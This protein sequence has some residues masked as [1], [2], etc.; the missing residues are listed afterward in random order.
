MTGPEHYQAAEMLIEGITVPSE[1]IPQ[2]RI[3]ME[4]SHGGVIALA[5]VHATLALGAAVARLF[6]HVGTGWNEVLR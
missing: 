5:Q 2:H 6:P 3:L 4:G 1:T